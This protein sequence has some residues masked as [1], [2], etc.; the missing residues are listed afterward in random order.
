MPLALLLGLLCFTACVGPDPGADGTG[1]PSADRPA[2]AARFVVVGDGVVE[3]TQ[4]GLAW[5]RHEQVGNLPWP[6]ADQHCRSLVLA[7]HAAWRLPE[8]DELS[9]HYDKDLST[10]CG[11]RACRLDAT[12][13]LTS[14]YVWSGSAREGSRRFYIDY[15]FG[16]QL[17]PIIRP[18]LKRHILCVHDD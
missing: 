7:G 4:S 9:A 10:P 14:P 12:F 2:A 15:A 3:D 13:T 1:A 5:T 18:T 8:I 6:E 17:A 16:T 11:E